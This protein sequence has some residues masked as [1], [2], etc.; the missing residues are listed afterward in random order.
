MSVATTASS[1]PVRPGSTA[2]RIGS[3][4]VR[5]VRHLSDSERELYY[6]QMKPVAEACGIPASAQPRDW[7]GFRRYFEQMLAGG[8]RVTETTHEVAASVLDPDLP[9]LWPSRRSGPRS[10]RCA[11]SRSAPSRPGCAPRSGA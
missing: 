11:W 1:G 10:R 4:S 5:Y 7:P 2:W 3:E 6:Q 8:L 9:G